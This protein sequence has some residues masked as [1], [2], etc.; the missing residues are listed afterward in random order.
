MPREVKDP[1]KA[2][3]RI[4]EFLPDVV[5]VERSRGGFE[6]TV[7]TAPAVSKNKA[8]ALALLTSMVTFR[9]DFEDVRAAVA[10]VGRI[11]VSLAGWE[12]EML[13]KLNL[14]PGRDNYSIKPRGKGR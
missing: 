7:G 8:R 6:I 1:G 12:N 2:V 10:W 14:D 5:T 4:A 13:R 11:P 3:E 9:S